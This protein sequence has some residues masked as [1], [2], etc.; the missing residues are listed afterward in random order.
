MGASAEAGLGSGVFADEHDANTA[1]V[2]T[3]AITNRHARK[4]MGR[5]YVQHRNLANAKR[6][7]RRAG[8]A[9]RRKSLGLVNPAALLNAGRKLATACVHRGFHCSP[10]QNRGTAPARW[11]HVHLH[12]D[13]RPA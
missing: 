4:I 1:S 9:H 13:D 2:T 3:S 8:R 10:G 7:R 5:P 11:E 6:A 12:Q